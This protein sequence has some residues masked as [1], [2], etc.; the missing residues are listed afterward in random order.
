MPILNYNKE[1]FAIID[2]LDAETIR[3][4]K[5]MHLNFKGNLLKMS[6]VEIFTGEKNDIPLWQK[7]ISELEEIAGEF[8]NE[9]KKHKENIPATLEGQYRA[10][11]DGKLPDCGTHWLRDRGVTTWYLENGWLTTFPPEKNQAGVIIQKRRWALTNKYI[12]DGIYDAEQAIE[13]L[14]EKKDWTKQKVLIN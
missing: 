10:V 14:K 4:Y 2:E 3:N 7:S 5:G 1:K 13:L 9:I 6:Q 8:A 12:T 11:M